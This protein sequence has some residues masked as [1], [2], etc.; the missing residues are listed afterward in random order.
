[1]KS[2]F[3]RYATPFIT[4]L[5]LVSLVSGIALFLHLG[6]SWFRAMHEWLSMVLIVPFLLHVWKNWR[7]FMNYFQR[8]PM[9]V[10]LGVS[11]AASLYYATISN[12]PGSHTGGPPQIAF[13][14]RILQNRVSD[15]APLLAT[16]SQALQERLLAAGFSAVSPDMHLNEIAA[17]S[18]KGEAELINIL[19]A[20]P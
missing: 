18:G 17:R 7:P 14:N 6:Q 16:S 20:S 15:V 5:F 1:M 2:M 13:A 11:L 12:A 10:A 19:T 3:L 8:L 9:T 4:G